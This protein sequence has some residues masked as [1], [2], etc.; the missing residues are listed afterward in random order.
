M[1]IYLE[2]FRNYVL[3]VQHGDMLLLLLL[4]VIYIWMTYTGNSW[5]LSNTTKENHEL[6]LKENFTYTSK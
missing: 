3:K 6:I 5:T 2:E 4:F 1:I